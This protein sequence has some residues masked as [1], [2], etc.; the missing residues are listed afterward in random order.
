MET[1]IFQT[2]HPLVPLR[3]KEG[4]PR[5]VSWSG[6]SFEPDAHGINWLPVEAVKEMTESHGMTGA[7]E[8][9]EPKAKADPRDREIAALRA[10]IAELERPHPALAQTADGGLVRPVVFPPDG[11]H[12]IGG[13]QPALTETPPGEPLAKEGERAVVPAN[14]AAKSDVAAGDKSAPGREQGPKRGAKAGA[15]IDVV[16]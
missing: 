14:A 12:P 10:R 9:G 2:P 13:R 5:A 1:V 4:A 16:S 11:E 7:P 3:H 6:F 8:A 15:G